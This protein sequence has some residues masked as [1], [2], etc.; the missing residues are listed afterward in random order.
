MNDAGPEAGSSVAG[1]SPSRRA[2][3]RGGAFG[4]A[5]LL[6]AAGR[7]PR[8]DDGVTSAQHAPEVTSA[9][10]APEV[11]GAQHAPEGAEAQHAPAFPARQ[12]DFNQGWLFGG[13]YASG[14]EQPG[15]YDGGFTQVTLPHT[16]TPLSWGNWD[17]TTWENVW[18]Y[19]KRFAGSGLRGGRVFADFDGVLTN[20]TVVLN[21]ATVATHEGGYLPFSAELTGHLL[22]GENVLAV[23]VDARWLNV[24][25]NNVTGDAA[26][27]D[28]LQPGGIYRDVTLR[29]VPDI[30]IS[31]V[32]GPGRRRPV[33]GPGAGGPGHD[34]R[35][36][37]P[38]RRVRRH[39][40]ASRRDPRNR[41][42]DGDRAGPGP[43][44]QRGEPD[45]DGP[46]R[47]RALVT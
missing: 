20:A 17:H 10:H 37:H 5:A 34:R 28:Y 9:Q 22:D 43:R 41:R 44:P 36:G 12:Y 14:A 27:V 4:G 30:Y 35:R 18:I 33:R 11:T 40:A 2:V 29:V 46:A 7:M 21:G 1:A 38:G 15:Y 42:R 47:R 26:S 31:D 13:A 16:V 25:P 3:L 32:L 23:I 6:A 19:R 45:H 39:R 8:V 24:P